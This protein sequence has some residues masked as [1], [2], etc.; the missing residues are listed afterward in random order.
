MGK[1]KHIV[2][3]DS[4]WA[5]KGEGDCK[6]TAVTD[7]QVE[8]IEIARDIGINR[9]SEVFIY[10]RQGQILERNTYGGDSSPPKE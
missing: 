2:P 8:A 5:V 6:N 4:K 9:S 10:N 7:T 1:N 3:N